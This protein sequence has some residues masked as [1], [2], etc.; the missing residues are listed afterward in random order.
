MRVD[1]TAEYVNESTW[2]ALHAVV[3]GIRGS[4]IFSKEFTRRPRADTEFRSFL[5]T[6]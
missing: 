3:D 6:S 2:D 4:A 1:F 5:R